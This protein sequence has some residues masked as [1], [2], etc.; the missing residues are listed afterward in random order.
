MTQHDQ[1]KSDQRVGELIHLVNNLLAVIQTQVDVA[2]AGAA[3][4]AAENALSVIER[5]SEK[6]T[7]EL[8]EI[9]RRG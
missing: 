2:R 5:S 8:T 4:G 3:D 9:R 6:A 1:E 7:R